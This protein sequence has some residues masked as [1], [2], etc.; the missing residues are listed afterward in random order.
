SVKELRRITN[1]E[2]SYSRMSNFTRWVLDEATEEITEKTFFNVEYQ[3][4]K[5]GGRITDI[6]FFISKKH[7]AKNEFYKAEEQDPAYLEEKETKKQETENLYV[8]ALESNYT[9]VL[10]EYD[11]ITFKDIRDKEVM[12][13]LQKSV[14]PLYD[15]LKKMKG[16]QAVEKHIS[17]VSSRKEDYTK[18]NIVRYLHECI[19]N[20]LPRANIENN[21][22]SMFE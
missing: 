2:K 6:K 7:V 17:Y 16:G 8:E 9:D 20:Y 1:T 18:R 5:K 3:K 11:L 14:Y 4:I 21:P 13:G 22:E 12:A 19:K 10:G 15:E